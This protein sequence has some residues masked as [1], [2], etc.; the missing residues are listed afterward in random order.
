MAEIFPDVGLDY[1]LGIFPKNGTNAATLYIGLFTSQTASTVPATTATGGASPTGWT[2]AA[3]TAY[4]RQS[5]AAASW[6]AAAAATGG[7]KTTAGQVTFPAVGSGGWGTINGFFI[8]THVSTQAGDT[9]I[10][11][12]NFDDLTAIP[13]ANGDVIKI[14][15]SFVYG[16]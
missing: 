3:G 10:F 9:P 1:L 13:S 16:G 2:E 12:S 6:G 8:A 4:A 5:I 7:R 14:T 15:P 11:F